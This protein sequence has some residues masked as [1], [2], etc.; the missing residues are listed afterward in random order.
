M[1]TILY[2]DDEPALCKAFERALRAP[3]VKVVTTTSAPEALA[4]V[5]EISFDV[6]ASDLRMPQIDGLRVLRAVRDHD[7]CTHRLLISGEA[8]A[9]VGDTIR[10]GAFDD[11]LCKPWSL[12][13]LRDVVRR[14]AEH[15]SLA[16]QT[17]AI[18]RLLTQRTAQA[19]DAVRRILR[20]HAHDVAAFGDDVEWDVLIDEIQR[21]YPL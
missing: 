1:R 20:A 5:A 8:E 13:Q 9:D 17:L 7:P 18:E 3:D 15:A 19:R 12:D 10:G 11:I 16:R 21:Q 4:L 6:V 14:G 2:V